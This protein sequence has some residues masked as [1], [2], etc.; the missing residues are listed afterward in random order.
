MADLLHRLAERPRRSHSTGGAWLRPRSDLWVLPPAIP[1]APT[2]AE[3]TVSEQ[4][5]PALV[6]ADRRSETAVQPGRSDAVRENPVRRV[7]V[8][9]GEQNGDDG[10]APG[11][12]PTGSARRGSPSPAD[13]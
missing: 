4:N 5:P 8:P 13:A 10:R 9:G 2:I 7:S 1:T 3:S 11:P 12:L 6:F